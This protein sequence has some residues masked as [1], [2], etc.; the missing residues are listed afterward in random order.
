M[1][2][3]SEQYDIPLTGSCGCGETRFEL[4]DAPL[5]VHACHCLTCQKSS[6]SSFGITTIALEQDIVT[7]HGTLNV[8]PMLDA[9]HRFKH[10]CAKCNEHIYT[11]ATNHPA[12]A[13][14]RA[15]TLDDPREIH[16]NAHIFTKRKQPW[17]TLPGDVPQ[18]V[19]GYKREQTWP[20]RS[21]RRLADAIAG[22]AG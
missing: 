12:T 22:S 8:V 15:G 13:L 18:F 14:F 20:E 3:V 5:F 21:L 9:P 2:E 4:T 16:I 7:T 6:G 19:E 1:K 10:V 17:L 11:T